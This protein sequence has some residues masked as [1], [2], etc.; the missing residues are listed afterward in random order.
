MGACE[1]WGWIKQS[2][3]VLSSLDNILIGLYFK[4]YVLE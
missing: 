1:D 4:F 2:P 3:K